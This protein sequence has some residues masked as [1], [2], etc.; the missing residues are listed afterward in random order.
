MLHLRAHAQRHSLTRRARRASSGSLDALLP[1]WEELF[2][3]DAEA[4]PFSSAGWARAWWPHWSRASQPWIVT[5]RDGDR[6]V[7]L[8]PLVP[9]G[10][11]RSAC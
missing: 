6:L 1:E 2:E 11:D 7:G 8:A 9:R 5:V 4:T 3:A 10:A